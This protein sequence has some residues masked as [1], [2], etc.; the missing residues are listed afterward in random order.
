VAIESGQRL[1]QYR[2]IAKMDLI[3]CTGNEV[4]PVDYKQGA[5]FKNDDGSLGDFNDV[6]C[7]GVEQKMGI[8]RCEQTWQGGSW[9]C[10]WLWCFPSWQV[11]H[12]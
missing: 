3:E 11:C 2:L 9:P 1:L 12:L 8:Q 6:V 5:P 10:R 7:T 4:T